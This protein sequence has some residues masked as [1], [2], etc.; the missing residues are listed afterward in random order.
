MAISTV[1]AF[2]SI[3]SPPDREVEIRQM[4]NKLQPNYFDSPFDKLPVAG[5]SFEIGALNQ[6][7]LE[8]G[9]NLVKFVRFLARVPSD[10][11]LDSSL[12][13]KAQ[14]GAVLLS[15]MPKIGHQTPIPP[16]MNESF[17]SLASQGLK[18]GNL[19]RQIG[20]PTNLPQLIFDQI[21][22]NAENESHVGHRRWLLNPRMKK[23]GLGFFESANRMQGDGVV[24]AHD[25]G[26]PFS[27]SF[28]YI[29]WPSPGAFPLEFCPNQTPWSITLDPSKYQ[30]PTSGELK[31]T[32]KSNSQS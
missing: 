9:I 23:I 13:Y 22:D 1:L 7:F 19:S 25:M 20:S 10:I 28:D 30:T 14:A 32:L 21:W 5:S 24:V 4:W 17:Y 27:T 11:E 29:A 3:I 16:K 8:D 6:N 15:T 26:R 12:S 18:Q 31:V 2:C